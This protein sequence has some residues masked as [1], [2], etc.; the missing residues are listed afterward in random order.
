M[1]SLIKSRLGS[2]GRPVES[3][4]AILTAAVREFSQEGIAGARIDSIARAARVN[5]A[6]V[7]YYFQDKEA[8]YGAVLD[9]VFSG[10]TACISEALDKHLSPRNR[11]LNYAGAHFDY[12]AGHPLYPRIVQSEL[13]R[14][15]GGGATQLERIGKQYFRRIFG[16]VAEVLRQGIASGDF[17]AVD[18]MHFITSMVAIITF[19]FNS[20][21]VMRFMTGVDPTSNEE[22]A[23]RRAAV[24]DF[25]AAALFK[26]KRNLKGA[27]S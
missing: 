5:K 15:G 2:R 9:H 20:A 7:Y 4:A 11:I 6:L 24:L 21:P 3:R 12:I 16:Q 22:V 10:L 18:E 26:S 19:Y 27:R 1:K 14:A 23:K 17:R 13:M 25:I 8:L